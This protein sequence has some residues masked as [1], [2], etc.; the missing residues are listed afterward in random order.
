MSI[1]VRI[2]TEADSKAC[3][4]MHN[5]A[6]GL[7]RNINQWKWTF[8]NQLFTDLELPFVVAEDKGKIVGT[9]ALIPIQMI[10]EDGVYWS[11]KSE[12]TF[13]DIDYRGQGLFE[14]MY[15]KIFEIAKASHFYSIWGFTPARKSFLQVGFEIPI[16]TAQ[17]FKPL[18][19][20]CIVTLLDNKDNNSESTGLKDYFKK[21]IYFVLGAAASLYS[22]IKGW[23]S[24]LFRVG[25]EKVELH[26][27]TSPPAEAK[28][29]CHDFISQWGGTTIYRDQKY[30]KWRIF[31]NPY[32]KANIIG[33]FINGKLVG[34][35][36]FALGENQTG[37]IID[38]FAA[39]PKKSERISRDIIYKLISSASNRMSDMGACG[40]RGWNMT[41]HRFDKVVAS[42]AKKLGYIAIDRGN[43]VVLH[44]SYNTNYQRNI[45]EFENWS[46]SRIYTEGRDG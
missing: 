33:A 1:I 24:K 8:Q 36:A 22:H 19:A 15:E 28:K 32:N 4:S 5:K 38:I 3:N 34:Y 18:K 11:A 39:E 46:V 31:D 16:D 13:V 45:D 7:S 26:D 44:R 21:L 23:A 17:L 37:Y 2:A 12:E 29:L 14:K 27:L 42:E 43:A 20:K 10:D 6:Y 40:I 41:N 35:C 9:Q 30:L 25:L